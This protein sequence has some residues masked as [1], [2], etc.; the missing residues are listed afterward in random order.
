MYRKWYNTISY[1]DYVEPTDWNLTDGNCYNNDSAA[2]GT[3]DENNYRNAA[4]NLYFYRWM[5]GI[6]FH[7][8]DYVNSFDDRRHLQFTLCARYLSFNK[9]GLDHYPSSNY[10]CYT[11]DAVSGCSSG[12]LASV[13]SPTSALDMFI[14]DNGNFYSAAGHRQW[15]LA[16]GS[17][18]LNFGSWGA[19]S[20]G[21]SGV[22]AG[23]IYSQDHKPADTSKLNFISYPPPG[24]FPVRFFYSNLV[25]TITHT[26]SKSFCSEAYGQYKSFKITVKH[27]GG[28]FKVENSSI[29][30]ANYARPTLAW[31]INSTLATTLAANKE[32]YT[33]KIQTN[34]SIFQF[35]VKLFDPDNYTEPISPGA[36]VGIA[37]VTVLAIAGI[38]IGVGIAASKGL[39]GVAAASA[40]ATSVTVLASMGIGSGPLRSTMFG[41]ADNTFSIDLSTKRSSMFGGSAPQSTLSNRRPD[42]KKDVSTTNKEGPQPQ[43]KRNESGKRKTSPPNKAKSSNMK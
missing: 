26:Q 28:T 29:N 17:S 24:P 37:T 23:N 14:R 34:S 38:A 6:A 7:E 40:A 21:Y 1:D 18:L 15:M 22:T 27:P 39:L 16:P 36:A 4:R 3:V 42:N 11:S 33:V 20:K 35:T 31:Q 32:S 43:M 2:L 41:G 10:T 5:S 25:H 9:L 8:I 13:I 30:C 12:N 19:A